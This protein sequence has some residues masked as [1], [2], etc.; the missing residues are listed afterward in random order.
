MLGSRAGLSRLIAARPLRTTHTTLALRARQQS[1]RPDPLYLFIGCA[2]AGG[3]GLGAADHGV[4]PQPEKRPARSGDRAVT[5]DMAPRQGNRN[6][7]GQ[8]DTCK[9]RPGQWLF[10]GRRREHEKRQP[11]SCH[12]HSGCHD[13]P[14][15]GHILMEPVPDQGH[16]P[17][18]E[19]T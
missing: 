9:L 18:P 11:H 19:A 8:D 2:K 15:T 5:A 1:R 16:A 3:V 14:T 6:G 17:S 7:R 4:R 13:S 10:V 12:H